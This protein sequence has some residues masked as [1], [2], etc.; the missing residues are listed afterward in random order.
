MTGNLF[1]TTLNSLTEGFQLIGYDWK[2]LL[3]NDSVVKQSKFSREQLL[4][5]TMMEMYPGIDQTL[6][7]IALKR[8]MEGRIPEQ[9]ENEFDFPDGSKGW[10]ELNIRP[11]PE[12][13]FI[14]SMD[15]TTRKRQEERINKLNDVLEQKV[16]ER[17]LVLENSIQQL[18]FSEEKFQKAFQASGV[19]IS[20]TRLA[21]STYVEVNSTFCK[22]LGFSMEEIIGSSSVQL[23]I[24]M[25]IPKR[26][27]ALA[28]LREV[29]FVHD[30]E[31]TIKNKK[32]EII[33]ALASIETIL[34]NGE[35]YAINM[36]YDITERKRSEE[37]LAAVNRELESFSY[38]VSHDLRAPLRAVNGYAQI[39]AEDYAASLDDEGRRVVDAIQYNSTKMGTLIDDLL[40][41]SRLG[42]KEVQKSEVD[43]DQLMEGVMFDI[44]KSISHKSKIDIGKLPA[45]MGDYGLI[46]QV[47]FNLLSNAI[48]YSS[49]KEN[50]VVE[51]R[52][53]EKKDEVSF[54]IK[55][56]GVG[57]DMQFAHKIFGVFQ[58]LH[59]TKDFEGTGVGLAIV[60]RI[61]NKLGGK[62][63]FEAEPDKGA[64]FY[65]TLPKK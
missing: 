62:I 37:Q 56:N 46:Q 12:G 39:L 25:D 54:S 65:F 30:L 14:L 1:D 51:V 58:R 21:D 36:I 31:T 41:F 28:R 23:G 7:F 10:F 3:V 22:M 15:I 2:Y 45:L 17:T 6:M 35:R 8:V 44:N 11:V 34:I 20:I 53:E 38:S 50:S 9:F 60:Q 40:N 29:G 24:I 55:D 52:G 47:M 33:V 4:G 49:T 61:I 59:K 42:R 63:W 64:T 43:M 5:K 18:K 16:A 13:I 48:K 32:G 26:D 27:E 57:F 19:A